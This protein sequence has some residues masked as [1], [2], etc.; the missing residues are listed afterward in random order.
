MIGALRVYNS[1]ELMQMGRRSGKTS[2]VEKVVFTVFMTELKGEELSRKYHMGR[3]RALHR[4]VQ[5]ALGSEVMQSLMYH[6]RTT[7]R[8]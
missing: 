1:E 7:R 6:D 2:F 3:R 5:H 4:A 8:R